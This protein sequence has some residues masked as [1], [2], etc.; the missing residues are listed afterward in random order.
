MVKT[1]ESFILSSV[2]E[3]AQYGSFSRCKYTMANIL[4]SGA[5]GGI[6]QHLVARLSSKHQVLAL[7][8]AVSEHA[9]LEPCDLV[10]GHPKWKK[11]TRDSAPS[12]SSQH[13]VQVDV[14]V[15]LAT[16]YRLES[17]LA[18]LEHL[19]GFA[20]QQRVPHF[21]YMSSW[22]VHFPRRPIGAGYIEMKRRCELRLDEADLP[23]VQIVRPSVV[24]G[25]GL[26]WTRTLRRLAFVTPLISRRF[27][28]S[29]VDVD[30]VVDAIEKMIDGK[31]RSRAVTVL[32]YRVPLDEKAS[33]YR[34][35]PQVA[36]SL[37]IFLLL[38]GTCWII[39]FQ[40]TV[41]LR[42]L[43][44]WIGGTVAFLALLRVTLPIALSYSSDYFAGFVE[45]H[46]EPDNE[47]DIVSL[48]HACN[49]NIQVRGY[50]NARL[51][52]QRSHPRRG[53]TVSMRR[54]NSILNLDPHRRI[55]R[56]QAGAHFGSILPFLESHGL[57]LDNYPN[58]HFIS[59]GASLA[60]AVHGS[61]LEYPFLADLVESFRYYDRCEDRIV[62]VHR[63]DPEFSEHVF[64]R[65]RL[66]RDVILTIDLSV[67]DRQYYELTSRKR[68]VDELRFDSP[69][70]FTGSAQHYEIRINTPYSKYAHL[71]TYRHV[72]L[73]A[74]ATPSQKSADGAAL[75][76]KAD[77]IGRRWNLIQSHPGLSVA[78]SVV[79][80]LF[81]NYEWFFP[82]EQFPEFW[83]RIRSDPTR[84]RMYKLLVRYNRPGA[85]L[86]TEYHGSVSIDVTIRNNRSML[87]V[88]AELFRKYR[89]I[90]HLGKF[91]IEDYIR[92]C[93][94]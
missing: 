60:T 43:T 63:R 32:G 18:M 85:Y 54:F 48:C 51:Y 29:F 90:E 41:S 57:W 3:N 74:K 10:Q 93:E 39:G 23:L 55:V 45:R 42:T 46:F 12:S 34:G 82:V 66:G 92:R 13:D 52:F 53:T 65:T 84:Y 58:Y 86:H 56:V 59:V 38:L 15:H 17:D 80:G 94:Q 88:S 8:R 9:S 11:T 16:T 50:D 24:I 78:S 22:V 35:F 27:S 37:L 61:N 68:A 75:S 20:N 31:I 71:Q 40:T 73:D 64:N 79:A 6:G 70:E 77:E 7:S 76:I 62:E 49:R 72:P 81:L 30:D 36:I 89:P 44:K 25:K 4:V 47:T 2:G 28:R 5:S 67:C 21:I 87:N 91:S 33:E 26:A 83:R 1:G 19:I 69:T 14:I